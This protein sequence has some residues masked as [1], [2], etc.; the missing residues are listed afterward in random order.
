MTDLGLAFAA[1]T[2]GLIYGILLSLISIGLSL[3]FG[4]MRVINFAHG[5]FYMIGAYVAASTTGIIGYLPA[6]VLAAVV[7]MVVGIFVEYVLLRPLYGKDHMLQILLTFALTL[8]ISEAISQLANW[9]TGSSSMSMGVPEYL[10]GSISLTF[11]TIPVFDLFRSILGIGLILLGWVVLTSTNYG[12][13]IRGSTRDREMIEATGINVERYWT[14]M[15]ASG[16]ALA[17]IAGALVAPTRP[18]TPAMDVEIILI[19]F[20]II[21]FGGMGSYVGTI[22]ASLIIGLIITIS[23][24]YYPEL[25]YVL[26]FVVLIVTLLVRPWGLMGEPEVIR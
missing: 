23:S 20:I 24:T 11:I 4:L 3:I 9:R 6:I 2:N 12:I 22:I 7:V 26:I 14:G 18:I 25:S 17:G 16:A 13:I 15:F 8:I 10:L 5:A 1:I 19:A 21:I